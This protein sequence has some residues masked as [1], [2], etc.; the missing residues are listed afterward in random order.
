MSEDYPFLDGLLES[1]EDD[2]RMFGEC[3]AAAIPLS[4]LWKDANNESKIIQWDSDVEKYLAHRNELINNEGRESF[5]PWNIYRDMNVDWID[6]YAFAQRSGDCCSFGHKNSLKASNLTNAKR[7]GNKPVEIAN[8]MT[9]ALARGNGRVK[10]GSGLNLNPMSKWAAQ[11]GNYWTSDFGKYDTGRYCRDYKKGGVLDSHALQTQSVIIYLPEPSFDCVFAVCA[12]G[13]GINMG[14]GTY[15]IASQ[16][17]SDGLSVPSSWKRGGHSMAFIAA[18]EGQSGKRY[19]YLEN[20]HGARYK[21]DKLFGSAQYGCWC[22]E[23]D[24]RRM[25]TFNYGTWYANVGELAL[26]V[27]SALKIKQFHKA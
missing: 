22:N 14:T 25:A 6:G 27:K 24:I 2:V 5:L 18:F 1:T 17:N 19:V 13:F 8:S 15:P 23:D 20:S 3:M 26:F 7:T 4:A 9:Y 11:V 16:V 10:F 12:A 21:A